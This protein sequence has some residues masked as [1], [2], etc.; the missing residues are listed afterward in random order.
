REHNLFDSE[1]YPDLPVTQPVPRLLLGSF[2]NS[3]SPRPAALGPG[4]YLPAPPAAE[5]PPPPPAHDVLTSR[6]TAVAHNDLADPP[7]G[8]A[9][10]PLP[11]LPPSPPPRALVRPGA[12]GGRPGRPDR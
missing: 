11:R 7:I 2:A 6:T 8:S 1:D 3:A 4:P 10:P 9:T 5:V 12:A